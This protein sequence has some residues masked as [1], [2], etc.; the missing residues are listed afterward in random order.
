MGTGQGPGGT[1]GSGVVILRYPSNFSTAISG[2]ISSVDSTSVSGFIIET[3]TSGTGTI[4]F[5]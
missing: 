4:T 1:G 2:I 3:V 5:S